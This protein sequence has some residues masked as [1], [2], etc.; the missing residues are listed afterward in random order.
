MS[1]PAGPVDPGGQ[2]TSSR[3]DRPCSP[4]NEVK[5]TDMMAPDNSFSVS[6]HP[7]LIDFGE[8]TQATDEPFP[9]PDLQ[10]SQQHDPFVAKSDIENPDPL[11]ITDNHGL[12]DLEIKEMT[13]ESC[14]L[15]DTATTSQRSDKISEQ[16]I[17]ETPQQGPRIENIKAS[18]NGDD[19]NMGAVDETPAQANA[20]RIGFKHDPEE[21][22]IL[23]RMEPDTEAQGT[24]KKK[25]KKRPKSQRGARAPTGFEPWHAD[26]PITPQE[27]EENKKIYD[28]STNSRVRSIKPILG[29]ILANLTCLC[30]R[31]D[32]AIKRFLAK[33]RLEPER[34]KV[35]LKYLQYGG[36]GVGQNQMQGVSPQELKEMDKEEA[37]QARCNTRIFPTEKEFPI[38]FNR[39][40]T[41]Y[42]QVPPHETCYFMNHYNPETEEDIKLC[43]VTM[44]NF[45]TYLLYHDVC[46]EQKEDL[47]AARETCDRCE[48]EL[49]LCQQVL[50]HDGPGHFNRACSMLLGGY[51]F[52]VVDDPEAWRHIRYASDDIFTREIARKVVRYAIAINGDDRLTKKFKCLVEYDNVQAKLVEDIDGFEILSI[53]YPS[54]E[55]HAYYRELASDLLP[56]GRVR[57]KEFRDE[58]RGE[59][60]LAPWEKID[61]DAGFA[62]AHKFE[63]FIEQSVLDLFLPGMKVITNV[64]ETNFGMHFYDEVM[65][66]LPSNYLFIYNDWMIDYKEPKPID[67]IGDE[68]EIARRRAEDMLIEPPERPQREIALRMVRDQLSW[69][70]EHILAQGYSIRDHCKDIINFLESYDYNMDAIKEKLE[71]TDDHIPVKTIC[72]KRPPKNP[73][74]R[75]KLDKDEIAEMELFEEELRTKEIAER[76]SFEK[77]CLGKIDAERNLFVEELLAKRSAEEESVEVE[78]VKEESSEYDSSDDD[79]SDDDSSDDDSSDEESVR[80]KPDN[81]CHD[82]KELVEKER[83]EKELADK[84]CLERELFE[85]QQSEKEPVNDD[86]ALGELVFLQPDAWQDIMD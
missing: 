26:A 51:Y 67:W 39:V 73:A 46:P 64:Y 42:L 4:V 75:M 71:L 36:V 34:R 33:R 35:F 19:D 9:V 27:F 12:R 68:N 20:P 63:F 6:E 62:P 30:S 55:V 24:K 84:E 81:E 44:K 57:A 53:E 47:E 65:T 58:S 40:A 83:F 49:W 11:N 3:L 66:V 61:W 77:G 1:S 29:A 8:E 15:S 85:K 2:P 80:E 38:S 18:D 86:L 41:G 79:S 52:E 59:F 48:K 25:N 7:P 70:P 32:E 72:V 28:P 74:S 82:V 17:T 50:H 54:E 43:T 21:E 10:S 37:M 76:E 60:D 22:A 13:K 56:V 31:C 78:S 69:D 45:F 14:L 5:P 16:T 23:A